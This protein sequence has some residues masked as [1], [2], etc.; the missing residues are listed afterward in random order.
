MGTLTFRKIKQFVPSYTAS[1]RSLAEIEIL[2]IKMQGK[3]YAF[4]L[5]E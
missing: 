5:K 2:E 3:Y 4:F 1:G